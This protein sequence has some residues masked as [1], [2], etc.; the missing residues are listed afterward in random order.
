MK[1]SD[2]FLG[3][4]RE[5][6]TVLRD[7][8]IDYKVLEENADD[9][10]QNRLRIC[11]QMRNYLTHNHDAGFLEVSDNQIRFMEKLIKDQKMQDDILK[12]HLKSVTTASC[13]LKDKCSDVITKMNKLKTEYFPVCDDNGIVGLV[14]IY[15]V[16]ATLLANTKTVKMSVITK[17]IK[18]VRCM[19]PDVQMKC[20]AEYDEPVICCTDTGDMQGKLL[21]VYFN[22]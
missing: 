9:M 16:S 3:L 7:Q 21:G 5:Y 8:G 19:Q 14:S 13:N 1:K 18:K 6:E 22:D 4:Y 12:K 10:L 15:D 20:V 2:K 17:F 11:R